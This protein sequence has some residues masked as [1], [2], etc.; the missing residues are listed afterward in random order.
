MVEMKKSLKKTRH[1]LVK[2]KVMLKKERLVNREQE[3]KL[4]R[5]QAEIEALN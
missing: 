3:D 2:T 1:S 5:V 4:S